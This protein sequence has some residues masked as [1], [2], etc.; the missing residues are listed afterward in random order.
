MTIADQRASLYENFAV[1]Y[2]RELTAGTLRPLL[3]H[4]VAGTTPCPFL[5]ALASLA[6][7]AFARL[8]KSL[9]P[10]ATLALPAAVLELRADFTHAFLLAPTLSAAP[11][12]SLY[13]RDEKQPKQLYSETETQ[14]R[15]F[16][17]AQDLAIHPDFPEPA[18]H[19]AVLLATAASLARQQAPLAVQQD[20]LRSVVYSWLPTFTTRCQ[21]LTLRF[22][23]YP[24]LA[25]LL[26]AFV[27]QDIEFLTAE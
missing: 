27:E 6:P 26:L 9:E 11:Y 22:D 20:F 10:V 12:A 19:L 24:A 14:V 23:F 3:E 25:P 15:R 1:L 13:P 5:Q 8:L 17:T 7:D 4:D 16:L 2:A 21:Q 18:D